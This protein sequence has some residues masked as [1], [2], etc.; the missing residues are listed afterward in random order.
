MTFAGSE[1]SKGAW[2]EGLSAEWKKI[3]NSPDGLCTKEWGVS[4]I[5]L[6]SSSFFVRVSNSGRFANDIPHKERFREYVGQV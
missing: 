4:V 6:W 2:R 5:F 3:N 1:D